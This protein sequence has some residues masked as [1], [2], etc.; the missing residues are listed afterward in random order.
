MSFKVVID[1][2]V[3]HEV[4]DNRVTK[5]RVLTVAGEAATVGIDPN[6]TEVVLAFDYA[7]PNEINVADLDKFKLGYGENLTG[8]QVDER[9]GIL[10]SVRGK[11]NEG[12][13]SFTKEAR[14]ARDKAEQDAR[15]AEETQADETPEEPAEETSDSS[16]FALTSEETT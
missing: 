6:Q 7:N 13:D 10:E 16:S 12:Q 4:E 5:V 9:R 3:V 11:T 15:E 2:E 14:E 8:E 1:G